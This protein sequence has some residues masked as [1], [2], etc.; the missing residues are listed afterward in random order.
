[1]LAYEL[2]EEDESHLLGHLD[3]SRSQTD[4]STF[5]VCP[6]YFSSNNQDKK[7]SFLGAS[8]IDFTVQIQSSPSE[9]KIN[10]PEKFEINRSNTVSVFQFI[11]PQGISKTQLDVTVTSDS[12]VPA[13]LKVSQDCK[14]VNENIRLVD[15]K[16]ESI[17]LSF[18][19]KGRI[20]LSKVS[21]P[22][23]SDSTSSWFIGIALKN[24][25]GTTKPDARKTV[26]LTLTKSFD[27]SY[28]APIAILVVT[29]F[30][31]GVAVSVFACL[32][33]KELFCGQKDRSCGFCSLPFWKSV[34]RVVRDH[35][36]TRGPKTYSYI[37]GIVG[38][39]LMVGAFQFLLANWHVM[40][41]E[42][43]RDNCY[44]NDFCYRVSHWHDIPFNLMISN[45]T[46]MLHGIILAACV[47]GMEAK[48]EEFKEKAGYS[49]SI[50]YAFAWA[51]IFEGLFS[52]IY[53][54]CPSKM[55]FQFDTAF[56]FV[57]AGLTVILLFNGIKKGVL[58]PENAKVPVGAANFFLFFLVPLL[59]FNYF[60]ALRHFEMHH[61]EKGMSKWF[62]I[63]VFVVMVIWWVLI[64]IWAGYKLSP[65]L[66]SETQTPKE[67]FCGGIFFVLCVA[68]PI[69]FFVGT[70]N[71]PETFLYSCIT[72]SGVAIVVFLLIEQYRGDTDCCCDCSFHQSLLFF[73][74]FV[75]VVVLLL[76]GG[77][78]LDFFINKPTTNKVEA[79]E[80]SRD[81]NQECEQHLDFFDY[82]DMWHILSSHALLMGAYLVMF[83]SYEPLNEGER[84][85]LHENA[86]RTQ[87][88]SI[89]GWSWI[90]LD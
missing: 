61:S 83:I 13:Y 80:I 59:I 29:T 27:Y 46:Y 2:S 28:G 26:T 87:S 21:L 12:D 9:I 75:Y 68:I 45:L 30:F 53:H 70:R 82:H 74:R 1:V 57:I 71:L 34:C 51:L 48:H 73:G 52:L 79:P 32:C 77:F 86:R 33:F 37:S 15:Y 55:T 40:I 63:F 78:A 65:T 64:A 38:F 67:K 69:L 36:F 66:C 54:L 72:I 49:F 6:S 5:T 41:H 90:E 18:A 84:T 50:G 35:W 89:H 20:T 56:M 76:F 19:K 31:S 43:D 10:E 22:P 14:D 25:T 62:E 58:P 47:C 4:W 81:L 42:G 16:G 44:Y 8:G 17:R 39:V 88:N 24:D 23:L 11:P 3:I 85:Q 7:L 60:G